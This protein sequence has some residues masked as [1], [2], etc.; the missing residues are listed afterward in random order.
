MV[1]LVAVKEK[2]NRVGVVWGVWEVCKA[3]W[4]C[5]VQVGAKKRVEGS[6]ISVGW[7][8]KRTLA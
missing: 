3:C 5:Q 4:A 6:G 1:V 7:V 2:K 8:E